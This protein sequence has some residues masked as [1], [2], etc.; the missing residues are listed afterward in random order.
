MF[1]TKSFTN[2]KTIDKCKKIKKSKIFFDSIN[3]IKLTNI[4]LTYYKQ[5]NVFKII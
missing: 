4:L 1:I 5:L 2:L 3:S